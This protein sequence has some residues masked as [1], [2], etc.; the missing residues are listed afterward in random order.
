MDIFSRALRLRWLWYEWA[1]ADRPW[2]GTA[3]PVNDVD[4]QLFRASTVVTLGNGQKAKFRQDSWLGGQA[5]IDIAPNLYKWAWRKH[6]R[7]VKDELTDRN[8]TRGLWR[9]ISV[10]EMAEFIQLWD[11]VTQ[12]Q[13]TQQEDKITWRWTGSGEYSAKSAYMAQFQGS[14]SSFHAKA[15]WQAQAEREAQIFCMATGAIQVAHG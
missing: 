2:V 4:R 7:L 9:M 3:P 6:H 11:L 15:I 5:P 12:T 1:D 8:W 10:Q 14:F 13:L